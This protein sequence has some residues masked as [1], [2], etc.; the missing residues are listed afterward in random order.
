VLAATGLTRPGPQDSGS[1]RQK[2]A[3]VKT[4]VD[5][6]VVL[7]MIQFF[8]AQIP[9]ADE[10]HL[11]RLYDA[12]KASPLTSTKAIL[13]TNADIVFNGA[14]SGGMPSRC[15]SCLYLL[16]W[17]NWRSHGLDVSSLP[18]NGFIF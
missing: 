15:V 12:A 14:F 7:Q 5:E 2:L 10:Q 17:S 6:K 18:R 3:S 1:L 13:K 16:K 11:G 8:A 9:Y 4:Y